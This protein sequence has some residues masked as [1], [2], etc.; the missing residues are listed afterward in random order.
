MISVIQSDL[1]DPIDYINKF[2]N[3]V[4]NIIINLQS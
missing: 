1:F 4:T 3:R 2:E